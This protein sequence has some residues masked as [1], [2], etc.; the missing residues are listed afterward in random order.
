MTSRASSYLVEQHESL[1]VEQLGQVDV[2][3]EPVGWHELFMVLV[4]SMVQLVLHEPSRVQVS[5]DFHSRL[6]MQEYV[7]NSGSSINQTGKN[8]LL[9]IL[10]D[11]DSS[12]QHNQDLS[13]AC[14][15]VSKISQYKDSSRCDSLYQLS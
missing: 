5:S 1:D 4:W 8:K 2:C 13:I 15:L 11:L 14:F 6:F 9:S 12:A 3:L 7:I 10:L